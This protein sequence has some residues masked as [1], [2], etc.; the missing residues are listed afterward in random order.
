MPS[1]ITSGNFEEQFACARGQRSTKEQPF[2]RSQNSGT[3]PGIV[4]NLFICE[5][6]DC[7]PFPVFGNFEFGIEEKRPLVYGCTSF[8][9]TFFVQ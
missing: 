6:L 9:K 1:W 8:S 4:G 7:N 3:R 2:E 5:Y